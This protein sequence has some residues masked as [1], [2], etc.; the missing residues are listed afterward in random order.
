MEFRSDGWIRHFNYGT[1]DYRAGSGFAS[2]A[3]WSTGTMNVQGA[4]TVNGVTT[5]TGQ[6]RSEGEGVFRMPN[7]HYSHINNS[8]GTCIIRGDIRLDGHG[9]SGTSVFATGFLNK[10]NVAEGMLFDKWSLRLQAN[11]ERIISL[12][13]NTGRNSTRNTRYDFDGTAQNNVDAYGNIYQRLS[14][15]HGRWISKWSNF[16]K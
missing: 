9:G 1:N 2:G 14:D 10:D 8:D 13:T 4:L 3:M 5:C 15:G 11:G 6:F 12:H 7:G 16:H